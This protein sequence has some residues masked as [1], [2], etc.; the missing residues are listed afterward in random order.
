MDPETEALL[1]FVNGKGISGEN[2]L[3]L[4]RTKYLVLSESALSKLWELK[5]AIHGWNEIKELKDN[6][7]KTDKA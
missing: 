6:N 5:G 7:G 4:I 3:L 2:L 1:N